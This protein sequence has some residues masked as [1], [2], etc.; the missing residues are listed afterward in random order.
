MLKS[1][2]KRLCIFALVL[3]SSSCS[4]DDNYVPVVIEVN[5]D[6]VE[7]SQNSSIT[8]DVLANDT[9]VPEN[10]SLLA[11]NSE[12]GTTEVLDPNNTPNNPT[13]DV[14]IYIPNSGY[15]GND[16]FQYNICDTNNNCGTGTVSVL[17]TPVSPV[18]L[19]LENMPYTTLSEYNFFEGELKQLDPVFGVLPYDLNSPLFSDYAHKKR[20]VWMPEGTKA[21]Y[22]SDFTPLDFPLGS[23]LIKNF[24]YDNVQPTNT[25]RIIETRLMYMT[26]DGWEFA[27]YVWNNE[28]TEATFS[29]EGSFTNVEWIE[30]GQTNTVNYRIPSRNECFTCHNKFGTPVPIGPKPQNLNRDLTYPEGNTNQLQKW[31][32]VGYLQDNLPSSIESTVKWDDETQD[33][34]LR[35]R[36]YLD[37]NCAH[38][39][40]EESY[41]E[42]RPMRFGFNENGDDTN[43]GVCVE[44]D[45]QIAGTSFI[46]TPGN[47]DTSVLRFRI[48][49]I[50][51]QNRMPI[52]GRTLKHEEGVRL[53]EE[54]IN[55]LSGECE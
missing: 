44:P 29:N 41:C 42:Y 34:E 46:V 33:L 22:N 5:N 12:N 51:E 50:E 20:F 52:I 19:D 6:T 26:E 35:V 31:I 45:T 53:I 43:K 47:I 32:N 1:Y 3:I 9:N 10:G 49:S 21:N 48:N 13:D 27:K 14:V 17:V 24:Y 54:W 25:T 55:S 7:V 4:E 2:L 11:S 18:S 30:D 39:H 8:I 16:S 28:Q 37:I 38:C 36:S 23:V 15:V 40:S